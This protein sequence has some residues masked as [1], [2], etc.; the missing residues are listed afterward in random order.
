[1]HDFLVWLG[2]VVL[3]AFL[4]GLTNR[5]VGLKLQ[6]WRQWVYDLPAYIAGIL[7]GHYFIK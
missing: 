2:I 4:S 1:M 5:L 6:G 3:W 7:I